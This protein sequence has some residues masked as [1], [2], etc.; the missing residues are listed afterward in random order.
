MAQRDHTGSTTENYNDAAGSQQAAARS[1]ADGSGDGRDAQA[2]QRA[3]EMVDRLAASIG[4]YARRLGDK[5][6]RLV[7]RA[8]EGPR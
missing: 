7:A 4:S 2:L 6:L 1:A 5:A 8:R 3:E